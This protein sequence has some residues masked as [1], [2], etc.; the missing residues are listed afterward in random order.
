MFERRKRVPIVRVNRACLLKQQHFV[1]KTAAG[2]QATVDLRGLLSLP[3]KRINRCD[4][5]ILPA[6]ILMIG[7]GDF[8]LL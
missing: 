7:N 8:H 6:Q 1:R 2:H 4:Q 3:Q 5:L